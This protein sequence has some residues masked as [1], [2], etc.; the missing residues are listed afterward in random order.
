MD[1]SIVVAVISRELTAV[2]I[3]GVGPM[4][5][6]QGVAVPLPDHE[7][8]GSSELQREEA[9][10]PAVSGGAV[11]PATAIDYEEKHAVYRHRSRSGSGAFDGRTL[12]RS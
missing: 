9:A 3:E 12:L 11:G 2:N 10:R 1:F 7:P 6:E 8:I 5:T 4:I